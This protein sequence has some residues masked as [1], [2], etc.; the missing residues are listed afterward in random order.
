M[1]N[2]YLVGFMGA[3]KTSVGR[4][5]ARRLGRDFVDLDGRL[6]DRFGMSVRE[7][8]S[9]HGEVAFRQAEREVLEWTLGLE[10]AVVATGGGAFCDPHN[11]RTMHAEGGTTVFLDVSWEVL[12]R[13]L[14]ADN[15]DRPLFTG[16]DA[17]ERLYLSRRPHYEHAGWTI[18]LGGSE[19]PDEVARDIA[20]RLPGVPCGT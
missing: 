15:E 2:I 10:S 4:A 6:E 5:L 12:A 11:R 20:A 14:E 3:G 19:S 13:R 8:F 9:T 18:R 17:A 7:V 1:S 16:L